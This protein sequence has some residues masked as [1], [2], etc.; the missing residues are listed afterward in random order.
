MTTNQPGADPIILVA[1]AAHW[2]AAARRLGQERAAVYRA[3][4]EHWRSRVEVCRAEGR[5][6]DAEACEDAARQ[7]DQLLADAESGADV[8]GRALEPERCDLEAGQ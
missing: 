7:A 2:D 6:G 3:E 5:H 8:R 4:A 1:D